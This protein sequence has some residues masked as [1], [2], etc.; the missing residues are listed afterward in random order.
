MVY[1]ISDCGCLALLVVW[2]SPVLVG[3]S[4]WVFVCCL[5]FVV[6]YGCL[7]LLL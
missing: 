1:L 4:L 6:S 3:V 5:L 2:L 7:D